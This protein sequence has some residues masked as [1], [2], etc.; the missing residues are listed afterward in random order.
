MAAVD[1]DPSGGSNKFIIFAIACIVGLLLLLF[2]L[3]Y[4]TREDDET[5]QQQRGDV[6]IEAPAPDEGEAE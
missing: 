3:V 2:F 1:N 4:T 6:G 5:L